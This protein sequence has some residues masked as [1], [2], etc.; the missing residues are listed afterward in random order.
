MI[1][2]TDI[3]P[4]F[5]TSDQKRCMSNHLGKKQRQKML[6]QTALLWIFNREAGY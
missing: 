4:Q 6:F 3:F 1:V 2:A 5:I